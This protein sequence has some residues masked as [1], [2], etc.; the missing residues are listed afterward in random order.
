ML[1]KRSPSL[2]SA[3]ASDSREF[4]YQVALE[5]CVPAEDGMFMSGGQFLSKNKN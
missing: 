2:T 1:A 4:E 3:R 5:W